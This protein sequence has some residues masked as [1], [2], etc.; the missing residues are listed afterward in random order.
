MSKARLYVTLENFFTFDH[1]NGLPLD[2]EVI[3]GYSYLNTSNYNLGRTGEGT[4][5]FKSYA[6]GVQITF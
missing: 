2:P 4:P 5:S 1:L 6:V 3:T